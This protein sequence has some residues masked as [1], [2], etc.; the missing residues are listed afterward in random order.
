MSGTSSSTSSATSSATS[1]QPGGFTG[2]VVLAALDDSPAARPV[3]EVA[4]SL[5]RLLRCRPEAVHV[6]TVTGRTATATAEAVGLPC[7]TLAG[8]PVN[9]IA[10]AVEAGEVRIVALGAHRLP[11]SRSPIG[12]TALA[13]AQRVSKPVVIVPPEYRSP[14]T[15]RRLVLPLSG[16]PDVA[17]LVAATVH[18]ATESLVEVVAV[19][20]FDARTVPRFWDQPQHE[21]PAWR[22]EFLARFTPAIPVRLVLR[23]GSVPAAV[24]AVVHDEQADLVVLAWAQDVSPGRGEV[25]RQVL[26]EVP[27]PVALVPAQPRLLDLSGLADQPAASRPGG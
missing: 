17:A 8:E 10:E 13:V 4:L 11:G 16:A 2:D 19:H 27:V 3:A 24:N 7:R 25:V 21:E 18:A 15:V 12:G 26:A 6:G 5:A 14:G 23:T 20:V 9:V 1:S 22:E